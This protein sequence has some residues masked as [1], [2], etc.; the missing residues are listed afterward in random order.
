MNK[1]A[2]IFD[3]EED[4]EKLTGL[5][6]EELDER[7]FITDDISMGF[8]IKLPFERDYSVEETLARILTIGYPD[9]HYM[10]YDGYA[11][12]SVHH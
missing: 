11:Y 7:G 12:F 6:W 9:Y 2:V 4:F 3:D 5:S 8:R 10:E 1:E